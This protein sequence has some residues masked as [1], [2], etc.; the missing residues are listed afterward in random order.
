MNFQIFK[1]FEQKRFKLREQCIMNMIG[2]EKNF[3]KGEI[4]IPSIGQIVE[5]GL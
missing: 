4:V 1:I 5:T 2:K 3:R